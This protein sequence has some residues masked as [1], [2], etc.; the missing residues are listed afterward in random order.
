MAKSKN[1]SVHSA[2]GEYLALA[3][4]LK[5]DYEAYLAQGPTQKGWDIIVIMTDEGIKRIQ[6]KTI[7]WPEKNPVNLNV[8]NLDFD[9]L[10][11]VLL[12]KPTATE[13][14]RKSRFFIITANEVTALASQNN[15]DRK[16]KN[17]T[18]SFPKFIKNHPHISKYED[19]WNVI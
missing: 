18:I 4:L 9:I 12:N 13:Q 19:N 15:P 3:E 11:V 10:I 5:R 8:D 14:N 7:D 1:S 2:I 6:V 17:R 16:D